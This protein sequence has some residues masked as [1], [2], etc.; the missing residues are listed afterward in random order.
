MNIALMSVAD[1]QNYGDLLFPF[2]ARREI[3]RRIPNAVFR[4]FTP[5]GTVLENERFYEYSR[6]NLAEFRPDAILAIGGEIIHKYDKEVWQDMYHGA[7]ATPSN[8]VFDWINTENCFKS[9]F[10]V[11]ALDLGPHPAEITDEELNQLD[12]I[13]VRGIL[14]KKILEHKQMLVHNTKINIVPDIGWIFPRC[15]RDYKSV[16]KHL[17]RENDFDI[18][19]GKYF[20]FNINWTSINKDEILPVMHFMRSFAKERGIKMVI[21]NAIESYVDL[22]VD[23]Q[24]F[25]DDNILFLRHL[26]LKQTGALLVGARFF[27]GSS[28]HCAIT[29]LASGNPA[30]VI[31]ATPL[32]KMQDLFGHMM[33][34]DLLST[35]WN[36]LESIM[37]HLFNFSNAE[38]SVL[39]QYVLFMQ[40]KFDVAMDNLTCQML[41]QVNS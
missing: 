14:S 26:S 30:G 39:K 22:P 16:L 5:T 37:M 32:T 20:V 38:R 21:I 1:I 19:P 33:K 18:R 35:D 6:H 11:G 4:F 25:C 41:Q 31:H 2:I 29:T 27:I 36:D 23:I 34:T 9:W 24:E 28:L 3:S 15:F 17:S 40:Q 8:V 7:V 12:F 10:S 13:G